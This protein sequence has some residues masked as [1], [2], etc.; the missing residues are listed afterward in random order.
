M[1]I[2][3]PS[4]IIEVDENSQED[5]IEYKEMKAEDRNRTPRFKGKLR[6]R[7]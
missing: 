2:I 4:R 6:R 3:G 7:Q 5:H 1:S